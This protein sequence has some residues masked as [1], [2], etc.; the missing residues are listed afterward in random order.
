[1]DFEGQILK[2]LCP[3]SGMADWY[4]RKGMSVNRKSG[5]IC[6]LELWPHPGPWPWIFKVIFLKA[7]SQEWEGRLTWHKRD[8]SRKDVE[9]L[10]DLELWSWPWT[11]KVKL[12]DSHIPRMWGPIDIEWKGCKLVGCWIHH[13]DLG[14]GFFKVEFSNSHI[15]G[16]GGS[17]DLERKGYES[18]MMLT[19]VGPAMQPWTCNMGLP[20]SYSTSQIHGLTHLPLVPHIC[21]SESGQHWFR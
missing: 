1:M 6:D 13:N 4:G 21:V 17:M 18:D 10:C 14:L 16:M 20:V 19:D 8:V 11:R 9:P 5:Q 12:W 3:W 2:N 15:S 7:V